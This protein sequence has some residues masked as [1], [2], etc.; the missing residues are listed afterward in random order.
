MP[1]AAISSSACRV[2]TPK[3]L[4]RLSV[5]RMSDAGVIGY[6]PS[7]SGSRAWCG[8]GDE[9]VRQRDVAGDVAV[10]AGR[11]RRG[12]HLVLDGERLGGLAERPARLERLEVGGE[13][14]GPAP[15]LLS[16]KRRVGSVGRV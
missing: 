7:T 1:M 3:R 14:L 15:N 9:P 4:S 10:H 16:R 8:G 6:E 5:C 12:R 2:V 11:R 13:Q